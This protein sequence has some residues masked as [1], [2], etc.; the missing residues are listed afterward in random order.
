[1][2]IALGQINNIIG[3]FEKNV[4]ILKDFILEA[5]KSQVD[6]IVFPELSICGYPPQDFLEF[7]E[8]IEAS[9]K[10]VKDLASFRP[11]IPVI[12]GAPVPNPQKHGKNLLNCALCLHNQNIKH[13]AAKAL[14]PNYDIFD[15]YRYFESG[16]IFGVV[17]L[18]EKKL[19]LTVCE[20]I[21]DISED[22]DYVISPP[23]ELARHKPDVLLN[24]SASPFHPTQV[25]NRHKVMRHWC[26]L[27]GW[28]GF[29]CNYV[30]S[31]TEL[32]FDGGS[33]HM[34]HTGRCLHHA[35]LFKEFL[36]I[37]D[38]QNGLESNEFNFDI[39]PIEAIHQALLLGIQDFFKKQGFKKAIVGLSGGID[40][41]VVTT[42]AAEALGSEQV[43]A[44]L[45]P[46]RYSSEHSISDSILLCQNLG[47]P[48]EILSIEP[49]FESYLSSLNPIFYDR[50]FDVTEENLQSRIRANYLM[51]ASNK[52]GYV[53]LNTSNKSE[54]A[55]GYGTLYGDMCGAL[56][57]IG[58]L[59]K[60][61]VYE[62]A[63][64]INRQGEIIPNSIII[65]EPSAELKPNQ[66]DSD[67]LPPYDILDLI[68]KRYI[69][70]REG[71]AK[72]IEETGI[73]KEKVL[74]VL[75]M[76]NRAEFKRKQAPPV[77]RVSSKAFGPGRRLPIV[78][79]YLE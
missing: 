67:S 42:L 46:S 76:V 37:C 73:K 79:K 47:V 35:P 59:F 77:L 34:D 63:R 68:L 5:S 11:N 71:P 15:E 61:Q 40:S 30:G 3:H 56:C 75:R 51:A 69:E 38:T 48:Y 18:Y 31:Q 13:I 17:E 32:I 24:I 9:N 26:Q 58:D 4:E 65:K 64:H 62:L 60:T 10:A 23:E 49:V 19:A 21:W 57:V 44:F 36:L 16:K 2:K 14:L 50:P 72:I 12:V 33:F 55:V 52:F 45:M 27:Y 54:L 22:R 20:D 43:L 7:Q 66:K 53:L 29:Y 28:Q 41:A 74:Q 1:V 70:L 39:A 6:L 8:F 25:K 78:G